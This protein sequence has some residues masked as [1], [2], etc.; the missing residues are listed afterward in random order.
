[1]KKTPHRKDRPMNTEALLEHIVTYA[2]EQ[3]RD[4]V[5]EKGENGTLYETEQAIHHALK[6]IGNYWQQELITAHGAGLC[7]PERAC[8]CGGKQRYHSQDHPLT[9]QTSFGE[10]TWKKRACYQC[11]Q[12]GKRSYPIDAHWG[13][14]ERGK[15]SASVCLADRTD[16]L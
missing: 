14:L 5:E 13:R 12:C 16:A 2:R 1:M 9:Q 11:E 10:V 4:M 6:A 15:M 8:E 3:I 7:G